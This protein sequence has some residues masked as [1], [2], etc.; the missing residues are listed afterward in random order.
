MR[1][2]MLGCLAIAVFGSVGASAAM[3]TVN[4]T[5][6]IFFGGQA[7]TGTGLGTLPSSISVAGLSVFQFTSITGSVNWCGGNAACTTG[8]NGAPN[9]Y[10]GNGTD[11]VAGTDGAPS[12]VLG[13]SVPG[14]VFFLVG[15]FTNSG[16]AGPGLN[17]PFLIGDGTSSGV[18]TAL[19]VPTGATNLYLGF[20][21]GTPGFTGTIGAYGDNSG[22]LT[23]VYDPS[24]PIMMAPPGSSCDPT[25][26]P[27]MMVM[28]GGPGVVAAAFFEQLGEG[29]QG[30]FLEL[31]T[32]VSTVPEPATF[33]LM[34]AS[35]LGLGL[36][37]WRR[38]RR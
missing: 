19:F 7:S 23:A 5:D 29:S 15:M 21:D 27:C 32:S 28:S 2:R 11:F 34:G 35:L 33:S 26:G 1:Q 37:G 36:A 8:P 17:Q 25:Q 30:A 14:Q 4:G 22:T 16:A 9:P 12:G 18:T 10:A 13:I 31:F 6:D 20:A 38:A 24:L 3:I